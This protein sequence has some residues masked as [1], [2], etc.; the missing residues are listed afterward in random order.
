MLK[1]ITGFVNAMEAGAF[2]DGMLYV[3][4]SALVDIEAHPPLV[5]GGHL[6]NDE[7]ER[8]KGW[9]ITF[10]DEDYNDPEEPERTMPYVRGQMG[11]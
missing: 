9:Y 8:A 11:V 6:S 3:N 10:T 2:V 7:R 5:G 4:D 1:T